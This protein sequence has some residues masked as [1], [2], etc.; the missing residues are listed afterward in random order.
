MHHFFVKKNLDIALNYTKHMPSSYNKS[1][2]Q[3]PGLTNYDLHERPKKGKNQMQH[4]ISTSND[5]KQHNFKTHAKEHIIL[6]Q[7]LTIIGDQLKVTGDVA[8]KMIAKRNLIKLF[9]VHFTNADIVFG[10]MIPEEERTGF[11]EDEDEK[12]EEE[13]DQ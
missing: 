3:I 12:D 1:V 2:K 11:D 10:N 13:D 9:D 4:L 6:R 7:R 5:P 8:S